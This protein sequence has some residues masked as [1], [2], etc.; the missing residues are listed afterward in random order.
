MQPIWH[1]VMV[2]QRLQGA[3]A[4]D[5]DEN[6]EGDVP[7]IS[8][9]IAHILHDHH[10]CL[11]NLEVPQLPCLGTSSALLPLTFPQAAPHL[12][13]LHPHPTGIL[14]L[15]RAPLQSSLGRIL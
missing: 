11:L 10:T 14:I 5:L 2:F 12:L 7:T 15:S 13:H 4:A 9:T 8:I 6:H 3:A 1:K